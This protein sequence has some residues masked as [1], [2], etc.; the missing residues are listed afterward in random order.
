MISTRAVMYGQDVRYAAREQDVRSR[1]AC[2]PAAGR[3]KPEFDHFVIPAQAGIQWFVSSIPACRQAGMTTGMTTERGY[4]AKPAIHSPLGVPLLDSSFRWNDGG[5]MS[6]FMDRM[7][8]MRRDAYRD[9]GGR[10]RLEQAVEGVDG[11]CPQQAGREQAVEDARSRY[12]QDV[13]YAAR[14]QDARSRPACLPRAGRP[15]FDHFVIPA[16][17]GIQ[18]FVSSIP[19][20][21]QAGMTT[22]M[23]TE[24]GYPAKPAIHSPL[25]VPLL[26]SSFR[27]N[28]GGGMSSFMDRMSCMRR[29]GRTP[30]AAM[31][32]MSGMRRDAYRDV[33]GRPRLE[34]AVEGV[35]VACLPQAGREQ[36]VED[37]RSR[38][39][40]DVLYAA[41]G[42]DV[43]SRP[44]CLPRAGK[45]WHPAVFTIQ[46]RASGNDPTKDGLIA[47]NHQT[48]L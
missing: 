30:G 13:L 26:D 24:R 8:C 27:W 9:A 18:W 25:G 2:L 47:L 23:T 16:Q 33:G 15:E 37:A 17:A 6:S 44:A 41:R 5:G 1:P 4:P 12:G 42:Q 21:R 19:A 14:G 29:E 7:S 31:D 46:S 32:R 45:S 35:D 36:A 40:Q 48:G 20:C 39:G 11:A 10:P 34:R 22:G 38:Y 43:R 28:D 3:Q